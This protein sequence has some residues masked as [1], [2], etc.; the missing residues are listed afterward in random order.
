MPIPPYDPELAEIMKAF[1][2]LPPLTHEVIKQ[3]RE[4]LKTIST[5]E[6][7]VGKEPAISHE[8]IY[9]PGPGGKIALSILRSRKSAG[10]SRPA[11]YYIH[12]GGMILGT[13][14]FTIEGTFEWIK[15]LDVVVISVE[16]RLAPEHPNPA[17]IEDCYAG[18]K[19]VSENTQALGIDVNKI[20]LAGVSAGGGLAA[21]LALLARDRGGPK[22]LAQCLIYPMLDDR[23]Q[24]LSS[25]Q[26]MNEGTWTGASNIEA[27]EMYIPGHLNSK[28]VS[29]YA[30]PSRATDLSGLPPTWIDVGGNETFRDENAE[31]ATRLAGDGVSVEFHVWPGACWSYFFTLLLLL[32]L[33][34][35]QNGY[36]S[37]ALASPMASQTS[38]P[39]FLQVN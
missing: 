35:C 9:I 12:G 5:L 11:V 27:W 3:Q 17:P 22:I 21:G 18:L 29:I 10:G 16:Y 23:M 6:A 26:F 19:W 33:E 37:P 36:L 32:E 31:Y 24:T 13:K 1:P 7:T 30:A 20:M 2:P 14:L 4:V 39:P 25:K 8:E 28:A 38:P 34:A 15:Q